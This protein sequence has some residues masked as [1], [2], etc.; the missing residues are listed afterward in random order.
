MD[1]TAD[2]TMG[3]SAAYRGYVL[4]ALFLAYAFNYIDRIL[5]GIVQEP[6]KA[7]F[8]LTD[9]QIGLLGGPAFA[10]LY[11]LLG[12]PIARYAERAS[13][14]SVITVAI[15]R[16]STRLNSSTYCPSRL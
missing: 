6:I 4:G 9:F 2:R 3:N 5:L 15:D 14:V 8:G 1:A 11:T 16:K 13:R 12:I 7:E 10:L